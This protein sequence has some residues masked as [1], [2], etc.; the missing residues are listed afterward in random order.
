MVDDGVCRPETDA[1]SARAADDAFALLVRGSDPIVRSFVRRRVGRDAHAVEDVVQETY[2][3]AFRAR[4]RIDPERP[5]LPWL[6]TIADRLCRDRARRLARSREVCAD[7]IGVAMAARSRS[8][9][10]DCDPRFEALEL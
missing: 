6:C 2:L 10:G 1:S 8:Q 5:I 3:R 9:R 4:D 7:S